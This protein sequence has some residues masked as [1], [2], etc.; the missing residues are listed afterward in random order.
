MTRDNVVVLYDNLNSSE[1]QISPR[2]LL[3]IWAN[4]KLQTSRELRLGRVWYDFARRLA[5][6]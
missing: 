5:P 2:M 6:T 3:E 4:A 1:C